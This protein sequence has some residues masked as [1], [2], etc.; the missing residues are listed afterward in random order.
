MAFPDKPLEL[1]EQV[2]ESV[3]VGQQAAIGAARKFVDTV[4]R[5]PQVCGRQQ[6][7]IVPGEE[8]RCSW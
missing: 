1:S 2:L 5:C 8:L 4:A 7:T 3:K 6:G